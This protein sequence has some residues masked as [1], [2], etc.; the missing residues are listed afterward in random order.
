[1]SGF[2]L[3]TNMYGHITMP[4]Q[5]WRVD[6]GQIAPPPQKK[7]KKKEGDYLRTMSF[8]R[9]KQTQDKKRPKQKQKQN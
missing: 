4:S 6:I 8:L 9:P 3:Y 2:A 5:L 1:M 7:R